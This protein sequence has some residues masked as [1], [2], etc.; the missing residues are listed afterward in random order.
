MENDPE[1]LAGLLGADGLNAYHE[2]IASAAASHADLSHLVKHYQDGTAG[3]KCQKLS[4]RC[5]TERN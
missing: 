2:A 1:N 3:S 4:K 5:V